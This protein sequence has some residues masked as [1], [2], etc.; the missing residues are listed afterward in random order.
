MTTHCR[1]NTLIAKYFG[2]ANFS[3]QS[4]CSKQ[5]LGNLTREISFIGS[6]PEESNRASRRRRYFDDTQT[7]IRSGTKTGSETCFLELKFSRKQSRIGLTLIQAYLSSMQSKYLPPIKQGNFI[8]GFHLAHPLAGT[9][10]GPPLPRPGG[11]WWS[12]TLVSC[13]YDWP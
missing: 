5:A 1:D 7:R 9:P 12:T 6:T 13:R 2:S 3:S 10:A 11:P 4:E 8:I